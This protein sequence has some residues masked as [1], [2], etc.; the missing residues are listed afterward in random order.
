MT[1]AAR[2]DSDSDNPVLDWGSVAREAAQADERC[3]LHW[4]GF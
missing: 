1:R 4:R 2:Q 3:S